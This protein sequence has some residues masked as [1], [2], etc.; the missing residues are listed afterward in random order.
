MYVNAYNNGKCHGCNSHGY[1]L[2]NDEAKAKESHIKYL[3]TLT[4]TIKGLEVESQK[5][6]EALKEL[7]DHEEHHQNNHKELYT[8]WHTLMDKMIDAI[9]NN[10]EEA[11]IIT[12]EYKIINQEWNKTKTEEYKSKLMILE[13]EVK[14]MK[15][16]K[17][18]A[19]KHMQEVQQF[20]MNLLQP[21][22][23]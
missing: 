20:Y 9:E 16:L 14:K 2:T 7:T 5:E 1:I 18:N 15:G 4:R 3:D 23:E 10:P 19:I 6:I 22:N 8:K 11:K 12:T 17:E 13:K 21:V